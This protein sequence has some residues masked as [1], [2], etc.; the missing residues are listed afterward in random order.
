MSDRIARNKPYTAEVND[1]RME[2]W[3]GTLESCIRSTGPGGSITK[4]NEALK[5]YDKT[6][7]G[8]F[9]K[10]EDSFEYEI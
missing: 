3:K 2:L 8:C 7:K 4:A 5:E 1:F 6:F 9:E 10:D